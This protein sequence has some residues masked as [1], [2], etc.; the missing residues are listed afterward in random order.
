MGLSQKLF[1]GMKSAVNPV[2][3]HMD[4]SYHR[5]SHS[6]VDCLPLRPRMA[7]NTERARTAVRTRDSI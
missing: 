2:Q 4:F 6:Q 3:P 7:V 5:K 1:C